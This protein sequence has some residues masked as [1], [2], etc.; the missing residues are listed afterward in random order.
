VVRVY[1]EAGKVIETH[2]SQP[3]R[4]SMHVYE[5]RTLKDKLALM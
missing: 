3:P 4:T 5:V 2:E 1:D